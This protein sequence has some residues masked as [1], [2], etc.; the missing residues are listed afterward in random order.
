MDYWNLALIFAALAAGAVVKGATGMG[1]PL[2][3]LPVLTSAFGLTHAVGLM[4]VPVLFSNVWQVV[5]LRAMATDGA[6]VFMPRFLV[7]VAAGVAV[8]TW[9]LKTLP[10]RLLVFALGALLVGYIIIRLARPALRIG[11]ETARRAG[12]PVGT[13]AG[14]LNG[15]TGI[16]APVGVT[17]IHWMGLERDAH[18]FAVSTMFLVMGV[19]QLPAM[20]VAGL[21]EPAWLVEG[22]FAIVPIILFMPVGRMIAQR[23]SRETF[24]RMVLAFLGL[25]GLKMLAGL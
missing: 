10:E 21:M 23:M 19:V 6:L 22:A 11:L 25:I 2:V 17:F 4:V 1:L 20:A 9:L 24:D 12:L 5:R 13:A 16:S 7:G 8:G 15:A 3:A 18:L 14:I